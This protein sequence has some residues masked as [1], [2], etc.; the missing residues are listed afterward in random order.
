MGFLHSRL[1][2]HHFHTF[3]D[4]FFSPSP[5]DVKITGNSLEVPVSGRHGHH[6]FVAA[7]EQMGRQELAN[8]ILIEPEHADVLV[9]GNTFVLR[10]T[11]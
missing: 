1:G 7:E 6:G 4:P 9:D 2:L 5:G 10:Y 11:D 3:V 8:F